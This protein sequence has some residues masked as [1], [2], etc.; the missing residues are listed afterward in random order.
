MGCNIPFTHDEEIPSRLL[1][2][3]SALAGAHSMLLYVL[4]QTPGSPVVKEIIPATMI[5]WKKI[6][7]EK[8]IRD[9][10]PVKVYDAVIKSPFKLERNSIFLLDNND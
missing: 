9:G 10:K 3:K 1:M 6:T 7:R 8:I 4:S 2:I 5:A